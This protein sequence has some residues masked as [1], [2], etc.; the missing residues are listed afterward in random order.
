[1]AKLSKDVLKR[2]YF[3]SY[4]FHISVGRLLASYARGGEFET[5]SGVTKTWNYVHV[6]TDLSPSTWNL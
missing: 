2:M 4:I 6:K 5:R 3:I 1:M